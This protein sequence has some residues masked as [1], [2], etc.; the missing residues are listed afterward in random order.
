MSNVAQ[1]MSMPM[2][3]PIEN[4]VITQ[5]QWGKLLRDSLRKLYPNLDTSK[6]KLEA[7][8]EQWFE[9]IMPNETMVLLFKQLKFFGYKVGILT[10]NV[11]EWESHWRSM[12]QLDEYADVI[13]DSCKFGCRKPDRKIFEIAQK[14]TN[15]KAQENLLIDDVQENCEAASKMGWKSIQFI[16]NKQ[17]FSE[18]TQTL[19]YPK[20][21]FMDTL[22]YITDIPQYDCKQSYKLISQCKN[23]KPEIIEIL[24]GHQVYHIT[25]YDD[26]KAILDSK[27]C[28]RKPTNKIGGASVLPTLTPDELLLNLDGNEHKRMKKFAMKEY[29]LTNLSSCK[30]DMQEIITKHLLSVSKSEK[31]D[32]FVVLDSIV[33]EINAKLLGLDCKVYEATLKPLSKTIQLGDF[34]HT[35]KLIQ[36]FTQMYDFILEFLQNTQSLKTEGIIAKFIKN[37]N[38]TNP[39]LSDKELCGLLL[40]SILGGYQNILTFI[41]KM[42]YALLYFPQFWNLL[43]IKRNLCENMLC[44]FLRLTNLGTTSTFPRITTANI[45]LSKCEIPKDS[46]VYADVLLANRDP[47]VFANPTQIN[48]FRLNSRQHLQFGRGAHSCMGQHLLQLESL[49][50]LNAILDIL[51]HIQLDSSI[52]I[53]WDSGV[54]LHRPQSIP[55]INQSKTPNT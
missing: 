28:I 19:K 53:K 45:R 18:I 31:F 30:Q 29:A 50:I 7:F 3:A 39:H 48:P 36:D 12:I 14:L 25:Q 49:L 13:V 43:L 51:P 54:I 40:G 47:L 8:G 22:P 9:N 11:I 2:L 26:V 35:D 37:K 38:A 23:D 10:N 32:L 52:A 20:N 5:E 55:V 41:S 17:A 16:T 4:A 6:A 27:D 34:K 1:T 33:L 15:T 21:T 44:E 24:S 46:V 42:L